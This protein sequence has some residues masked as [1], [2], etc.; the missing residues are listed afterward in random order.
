MGHSFV[1]SP[2]YHSASA[3]AWD[4]VTNCFLK[5]PL[6]INQHTQ[7][8]E[9]KM[10]IGGLTQEYRESCGFGLIMDVN[11]EY[12]SVMMNKMPVRYHDFSSSAIE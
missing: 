11:S 1:S 8:I 5:T 9:N 12:P 4:V 2:F 3:L 6:F 10:K 7:L